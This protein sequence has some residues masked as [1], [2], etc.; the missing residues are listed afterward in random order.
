MCKWS[1]WFWI[2]AEAVV[3]VSV[4]GFFGS[5]RFGRSLLM[6]KCKSVASMRC[7]LA[8]VLLAAAVAARLH[9]NHCRRRHNLMIHRHRHTDTRSK[10]TTPACCNNVS[11]SPASNSVDLS[12]SPRGTASHLLTRSG[13]VSRPVTIVVVTVAICGPESKRRGLPV[14]C[15]A[16]VNERVSMR[17]PMSAN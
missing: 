15:R 4:C 7:D 9:T 10:Q 17:A 2:I 16:R 12:S 11:K 14:A 13:P 8:E 3:A 6:M 5:V 1:C